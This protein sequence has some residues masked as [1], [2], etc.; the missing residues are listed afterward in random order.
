MQVNI[1]QADFEEPTTEIESQDELESGEA[2]DLMLS[3]L[4][5]QLDHP[6]LWAAIPQFV[7]GLPDLMSALEARLAAE[8]NE[9]D[10]IFILL[11]VAMVGASL[12]HA[13]LMLEQ[14]RPLSARFSQSPLVQGAI[15][16]LESLCDPDDPKYHL[17]ERFCPNP[18]MQ[19]DV[20]ENSTHLCCASYLLTSAGNLKEADWEQVWNSDRAQQIRESIH[21]GSYRYC[22]KTACPRIQSGNVPTHA[23]QASQSDF[24]RETIENRATSLP[25]GPQRVN[26]AYDRTCNLSCPS[27]RVERYA[28]DEATRSAYDQLQKRA[29]LPLLKQAQVVF[30]T[31]SG[32]PFA[33]KNFRRLME[34]LTPDEYPDLRFQVMTNGM[35][36]T[37]AQWA[38]FPTLHGRTKILKISIDAATGPTHERL[39]RG[40]RWPVMLENMAFAGRLAAEG[41]IENYELV[42]TVQTDNYREMGD[43]VD[44]AHRMGANSVFFARLTNWGTFGV[45]EYREKAVFLP[46]HPDHQDFLQQMRDPRLRDPIVLPGDLKAFIWSEGREKEAAAA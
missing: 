20:L 3:I 33:S 39:R 4:S 34:S 42:F 41:L 29:I 38:Q 15:F 43:A 5:D 30:I 7:D 27:C 28:A 19:F 18:F 8:S 6:E 13:P 11:L 37:P 2:I 22:N 26:L 14:I 35:L 40:A 1:G 46:E 12:G 31:G 10:R 25:V 21:D 23:E 44:L 45:E 16:H 24:W 36:L 17:A 32:D 9:R